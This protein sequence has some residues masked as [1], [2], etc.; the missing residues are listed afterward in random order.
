MD[1][2]LKMVWRM[3]WYGK[4]Q[5]DHI[6]S[7]SICVCVFVM[8]YGTMQSTLSVHKILENSTNVRLHRHQNPSICGHKLDKLIMKF[9]ADDFKQ[10]SKGLIIEPGDRKTRLKLKQEIDSIKNVLLFTPASNEVTLYV[11]SLM[12]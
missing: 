4:W 11:E 7:S 1:Y 5:N 2:Y 6:S 8:D 10:K 12:E 3:V 9:C